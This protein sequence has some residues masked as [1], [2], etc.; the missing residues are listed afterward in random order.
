[1]IC[2]NSAPSL[3]NRRANRKAPPFIKQSF[4]QAFRVMASTLFALTFA[5]AAHVQG[6]IDSS[7]ADAHGDL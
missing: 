2:Q 1:M 4:A 7:G 3:L 6:T 5:G